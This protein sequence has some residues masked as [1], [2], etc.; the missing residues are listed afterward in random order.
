MLNKPVCVLL[1][2]KIRIKIMLN[3]DIGGHISSKMTIRQSNEHCVHIK[4]PTSRANNRR[5]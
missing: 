1:I 4:R 5:F 3:T 2:H